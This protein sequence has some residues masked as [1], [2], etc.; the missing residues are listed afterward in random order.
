MSHVGV[1]LEGRHLLKNLHLCEKGLTELVC[2]SD[3][4]FLQTE[5]HRIKGT[6]FIYTRSKGLSGVAFWSTVSFQSDC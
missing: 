2:F 1:V 3:L 5:S 4:S 6:Q